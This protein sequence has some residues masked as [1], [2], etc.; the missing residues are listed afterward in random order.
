MKLST[1]GRYGLKAMFELACHYG[2]GPVRLKIIAE[3]QNIS[4]SYLEQLLSILRKSGL[5]KSIRGS[6]GGYYLA[7]SPEVVTVGMVIKALEG[8]LAPS[9][10]SSE[11]I[12]NVCNNENRCVTKNIMVK[13]RNSIHSVIDN[14]SLQDMLNENSIEITQ[15]K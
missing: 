5:V 3:K 2:Q 7:H 1:K 14:I 4:E 13:I 6:Q 12:E 15:N 8:D 9:Q 10:C 11:G